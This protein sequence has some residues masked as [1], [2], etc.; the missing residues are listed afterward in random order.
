MIDIN[1]VIK[2]LEYGMLTDIL[3]NNEDYVYWSYMSWM[4]I[5]ISTVDHQFTPYVCFIYTSFSLM[6][7]IDN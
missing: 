4:D 1:K 6:T 3:R 5:N 7:F 2:Y